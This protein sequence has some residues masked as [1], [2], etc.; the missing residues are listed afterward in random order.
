VQRSTRSELEGKATPV[1]N[2]STPALL[3]KQAER[4]LD[5]AAF[6]FI[7]PADVLL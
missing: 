7:Q 5:A 6:A 1:T 2:S 3:D 4:L